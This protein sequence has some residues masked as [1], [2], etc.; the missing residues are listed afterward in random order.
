MQIINKSEGE[1]QLDCGSTPDFASI[2]VRER[3]GNG[4]VFFLGRC[5]DGLVSFNVRRRTPFRIGCVCRRCIAGEGQLDCG[6]TPDFASI[7]VRETLN[8]TKKLSI[9]AEHY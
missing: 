3:I 4:M 8:P 6:S 7:L 1:G 5:K 9:F 2:L